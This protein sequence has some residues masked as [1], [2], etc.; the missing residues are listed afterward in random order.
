[1]IT[2]FKCKPNFPLVEGNCSCIN[3]AEE[4]CWEITQTVGSHAV[5]NEVPLCYSLDFSWTFLY[6]RI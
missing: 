3:V 1:M 2:F 5:A 6:I 4:Y